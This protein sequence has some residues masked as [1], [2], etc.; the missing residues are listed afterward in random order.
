MSIPSGELADYLGR[1]APEAE[2]HVLYLIGDPE[3]DLALQET[4]L[5]QNIRDLQTHEL[6]CDN[7]HVWGLRDT[8]FGLELVPQRDE[9]P[10]AGGPYPGIVNAPT[11]VIEYSGL[12]H[13]YPILYLVPMIQ[14]QIADKFDEFGVRVFKDRLRNRLVSQIMSQDSDAITVDVSDLLRKLIPIW[15]RWSTPNRKHLRRRTRRFIRAYLD[16]LARNLDIEVDSLPSGQI[17]VAGLSREVR[18][19]LSRQLSRTKQR[20]FLPDVDMLQISIEDLEPPSDNE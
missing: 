13:T 14:G 19:A 2:H 1:S 15:D 8:D 4:T 20:R 16:N 6:G 12:E 10:H 17:E 11:R 18:S 7:Y 5:A 9:I 3:A